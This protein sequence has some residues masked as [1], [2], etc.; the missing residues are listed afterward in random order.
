VIMLRIEHVITD[1]DPLDGM[2]VVPGFSDD[3]I[4]WACV[5][6]LPGAR[7]RWRRIHTPDAPVCGPPKGNNRHE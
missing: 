5:G 4:F 1:D 3:E 2:P 6:P 7:T